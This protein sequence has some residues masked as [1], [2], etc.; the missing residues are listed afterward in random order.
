MA[1]QQPLAGLQRLPHFTPHVAALSRL[2]EQTHQLHYAEA[3]NPQVVEQA[4]HEVDTVLKQQAHQASHALAQRVLPNL[5]PRDQAQF[6][7]KANTL[8]LGK[9][10]P[11]GWLVHALAW[12]YLPAAVLTPMVTHATLAQHPDV[13]SPANCREQTRAE[14]W[15]QV[16][17]GSIHVINAYLGGWAFKGLHTLTQQHHHLQRWADGCQGSLPPLAA[18]LSHAAQY[19]KC[20]GQHLGGSSQET[21]GTLAFMVLGSTLGYGVVRPYISMTAY[22]HDKQRALHASHDTLTS[23]TT[24]GMNKGIFREASLRPVVG[25]PVGG[26]V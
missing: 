9:H 19:L 4:L 16:T 10:N 11:Q 15:R 17:S 26:S 23:P 7:A 22:T 2:V 8:L 5:P 24:P 25:Q 3:P 12:Q 21:A 14:V 18:G 1:L 20:W 13:N 6:T